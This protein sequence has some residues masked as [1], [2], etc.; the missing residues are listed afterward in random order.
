MCCVY[1]PLIEPEAARSEALQ[2]YGYTCRDCRSAAPQ[3]SLSLMPFAGE[4]RSAR[5]ARRS[6][7]AIDDT[8]F[9]SELFLRARIVVSLG[10]LAAAER[11]AET[12]DEVTGRSNP[13]H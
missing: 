1:A 7:V 11:G 2:W 5:T 12:T 4:A 8:F 9:P 6:P 13:R 10:L 3:N